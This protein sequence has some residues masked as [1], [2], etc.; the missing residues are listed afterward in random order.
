V[1]A[2]EIPLM[3]HFTCADTSATS[4]GDS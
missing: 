1:L 4:D 3:T 2:A